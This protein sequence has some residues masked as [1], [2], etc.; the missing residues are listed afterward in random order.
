ML[1]ALEVFAGLSAPVG[2]HVAVGGQRQKVGSADTWL[3][4]CKRQEVG[5]APL[6]AASAVLGLVAVFHALWKT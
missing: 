3:W 6:R 5:T 4:D 2:G 1:C